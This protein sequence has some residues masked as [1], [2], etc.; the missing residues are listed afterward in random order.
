MMPQLK[1]HEEVIQLESAQLLLKVGVTSALVHELVLKGFTAISTKEPLEFGR[2]YPILSVGLGQGAQTWRLSQH[3]SAAAT[4]IQDD[5]DGVSRQLTLELDQQLPRFSVELKTE[6]HSLQP[7]SLQAKIVS[8]WGRSDAS[9]GRGSLLETVILTKKQQ[10]WQRMYL[11]YFGGTPP[12]AVPRGTLLLT[13]AE[14]FFCQSIKLQEPATSAILAAPE[15]GKTIAASLEFRLDVA[16]GGQAHARFEVYVGPRD[17]FRLRDAGFAEAFPVGILGRVGLILMLFLK[18]V[19]SLTHNY[20]VA[21]VL[22]S[23][24]VTLAL[25]PFTM[26][27][28]RS[29]K[30]MQELQPKLQHLKNKY[31]ND[32]QRMN[33]ESF[34]LFKEHRVSP[35]GG[36]L[37]LLLSLPIFFAIWSA[38]SHVIELRGERFL[39]IKD[40]SLPDKLA[41]LP[42]GIE[43]NILPIIM[44]GAMFLQTK[45]SQ[46]SMPQTDANPTARVMSGPM[47]P[48][49]FG[50]MFYQ[51]PSG[52]VLYWLM[53]SLSTLAV[54][55]IAKT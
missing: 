12:R 42:F 1:A 8:S 31:K 16:P 15:P 26:M 33:Q 52:L 47:M 7:A 38:I 18:G 5:E 36:C 6:S 9:G 46:S 39:W 14:R 3:S 27:S 4:W 35:L 45:M 32:T 55:R 54:Y 41:M 11:R 37:P 21:I 17:F 34:A 44:A 43:L 28:V 48:V 19:A 50:F 30:K 24:M 22:L 51:L 49:L 40:L 2:T 10:P 23:V 53:N 13:Q 25:S 20:G 29:M